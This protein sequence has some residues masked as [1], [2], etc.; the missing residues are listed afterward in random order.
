MEKETMMTTRRDMI[1]LMAS[2]GLIATT[3]PFA[4]AKAPFSSIANAGYYRFRFGSFE[5]TALSDGT[6]PLPMGTI[7]QDAPEAHLNEIL[8]NNLLGREPHI[9]INA[10]LLNDSNRLILVDAGTGSLFGP[11]AGKLIANLKK[12]GYAPEQVDAVILTHIHADHSGGLTVDGV[13]QF[14]NADVMVPDREYTYWIDKLYVGHVVAGKEGEF[15]QAEAALR[16]YIESGR[17]K[18]FGPNEAPLPG[19]G[20]ILRAGHTPGH[21]SIFVRN[22]D[23]EKF[24]IWGDIIHGDYVQFDEPDIYVTFDVDGAEAVKTR[25]IALQ[26]AADERYLVAGAHLPFPG[27]GYVTRDSTLYRWVR[28]NYVE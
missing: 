3:T 22:E 7:Y 18:H 24:V 10:Y 6:L 2:A 21:S 9:S 8:D 11:A 1:K 19:F 26:E 5:V 4:F 25:E 23:G 14:P 12:S 15:A 13:A 16:P 17:V 28:Q 20:S 27:I